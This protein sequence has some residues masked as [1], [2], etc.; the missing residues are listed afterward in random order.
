M[1][2]VIIWAHLDQFFWA[3]DLIF[4]TWY[5]E[6]TAKNCWPC[7]KTANFE[8]ILYLLHQIITFIQYQIFVEGCL[9][10]IWYLFELILTTIKPTRANFLHSVKTNIT[11]KMPNLQ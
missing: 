9:L 3:K 4:Y 2:A 10:Y 5:I 6:N 11:K 7:D 1:H 8:L